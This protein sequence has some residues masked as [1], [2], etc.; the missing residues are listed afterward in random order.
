MH[1]AGG[2]DELT[3]V[4]ANGDNRAMFLSTDGGLRL[5]N[6]IDVLALSREFN[7]PANPSDALRGG[8][9]A[10][11]GEA[12]RALLEGRMQ[13]SAYEATVL[14]NATAALVAAGA[15]PAESEREG[16][17]LAQDSIASGRALAALDR[18]IEITRS[19]P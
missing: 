2:I 19:A 14:L 4:D 3:F 5:L 9:A 10:Y 13:H 8:D 15:I 12:L 11:N 6:N 18:L 7:V 16:W 17:R 1:G